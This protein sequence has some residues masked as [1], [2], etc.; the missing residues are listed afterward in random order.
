MPDLARRYLEAAALHLDVSLE[1]ADVLA[2]R[3]EGVPELHITAAADELVA[4]LADGGEDALADESTSMT[5]ARIGA[6]AV[7]TRAEM[8]AGSSPKVPDSGPSVL[9]DFPR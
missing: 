1:P 4:H 8:E 6:Q 9:E 5:L 7:M 2:R 3:A